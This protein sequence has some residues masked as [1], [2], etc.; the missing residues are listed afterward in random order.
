MTENVVIVN[1]RLLLYIE[2]VGLLYVINFFM[3]FS[4][5]KVRYLINIIFKCCILI[6][7]TSK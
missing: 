6:R 7:Y 5:L 4:Y 1:E 3:H 2:R